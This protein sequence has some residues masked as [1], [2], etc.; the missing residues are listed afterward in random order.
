MNDETFIK[1]LANMSVE[2]IKELMGNVAAGMSNEDLEIM[3]EIEE[4]L[5]GK[6]KDG[7]LRKT[8]RIAV[9][10]ANNLASFFQ[11]NRYNSEETKI[12]EKFIKE[13]NFFSYCL[14]LLNVLNDNRDFHG[15]GI[16]I[17]E[18]ARFLNFS[19]G[20]SFNIRYDYSNK[21]PY[22][23]GDCDMSCDPSTYTN[24]N[25]DAPVKF[26]SQTKNEFAQDVL[27]EFKKKNIAPD[28]FSEKNLQI[29]MMDEYEEYRT[30]HLDSCW[31]DD[32]NYYG[33]D[34]T[35]IHG[36]T[37]QNIISDNE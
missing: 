33:F 17:D 34:D 19:Y 15:A 14:Y 23:D 24:C 36:Y 10:D 16:A 37:K 9:K 12:F 8:K 2:D 11:E 7:Y 6:M 22:K 1:M 31:K 13:N 3:S 18:M 32:N 4:E 25:M 28:I 29:S 27:N 5:P 20:C 35:G 30:L 21:C 26:L